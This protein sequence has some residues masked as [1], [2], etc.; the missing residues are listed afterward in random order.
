MSKAK[1]VVHDD[2]TFYGIRFC[3]PGC[4]QVRDGVGS[5]VV[6]TVK[7][8]PEG[9]TRSPH[10]NEQHCWGFDGNLDNPTLTPSVLQQWNQWQGEGVPAKRHVC[11]SFVRN[12][13]IE[14]LGDSTHSLAGQTV[15]L[16]EIEE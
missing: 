8:T 13:R 3:C 4:A 6:L 11:H 2:G 10:I 12:G 5:W 14:F 1:I 7:W 15:D 9:Y 16:P